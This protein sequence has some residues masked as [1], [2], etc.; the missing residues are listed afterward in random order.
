MTNSGFPEKYCAET[1]YSCYQ[2]ELKWTSFIRADDMIPINCTSGESAFTPVSKNIVVSCFRLFNQNA[3]NWIQ[4]LAISNALALLMS[5]VFEVLVWVCV[6]SLIWMIM[7]SLFAILLLVAVIL[8]GVSGTFTAFVNS[9]LGF[10]AV[11]ICPFFIYMIR[12]VAIEIRRLKRE[13]T[14][15][16]QE[17]TRKEFK[18]IGK[19]FLAPTDDIT[20]SK[21]K[22]SSLQSAVSEDGGN[23]RQRTK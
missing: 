9:W 18:L 3:P 11:A 13:E 10:I 16:I 1:D 7:L 19:K 15:R 6:E 20:I 23:L 12:E 2:T 22:S 17:R 5:R 21:H 8:T 14:A 4:N